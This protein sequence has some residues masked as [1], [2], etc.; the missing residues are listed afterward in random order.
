MIKTNQKV[1]EQGIRRDKTKNMV[2]C[3][4]FVTL[5]AAG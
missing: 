3:A 1:N 5:I 4:M 2:L